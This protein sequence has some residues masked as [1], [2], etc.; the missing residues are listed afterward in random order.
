ME[1]LTGMTRGL[2]DSVVFHSASAYRG[3]ILKF[4]AHKTPVLTGL[5]VHQIG[6]DYNADRNRRNPNAPADEAL[7]CFF[8]LGYIHTAVFICLDHIRVLFL[9]VF[10][11]MAYSNLLAK[12]AFIGH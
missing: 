10:V 4:Q 9:P 3:Q 12:S 8:L 2:I 1:K 6:K 7:K 11:P 5:T